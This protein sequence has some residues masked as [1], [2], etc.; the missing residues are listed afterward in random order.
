MFNLM[1][2]HISSNLYGRSVINATLFVLIGGHV[3][4][5][6]VEY[7]SVVLDKLS[8]LMFP[9]TDFTLSQPVA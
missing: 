5:E 6:T 4:H 7:Q 8:R 2:I 1:Y 9:N 3:K